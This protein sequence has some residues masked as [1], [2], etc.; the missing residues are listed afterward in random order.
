MKDNECIKKEAIIYHKGKKEG[1][2]QELEKIENALIR[3]IVEISLAKDDEDFQG[4]KLYFEGQLFICNSLLKQIQ[5]K[6]KEL[7]A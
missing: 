2:R 5:I 4:D 7:G 3:N 6:L 1:A